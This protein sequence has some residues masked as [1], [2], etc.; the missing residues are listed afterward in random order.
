MVAVAMNLVASK[1]LGPCVRVWCRWLRA[2]A[3]VHATSCRIAS[4]SEVLR[5][6]HAVCTPRVHCRVMKVRH[7]ISIHFRA[8]LEGCRVNRMVLKSLS[9]RSNF[10]LSRHGCSKC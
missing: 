9:L 6:H 10:L 2:A 8:T 4:S 7:A 5:V 3:V 1:A